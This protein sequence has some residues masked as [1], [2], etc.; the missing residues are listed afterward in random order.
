[1]G[2]EALCLEAAAGKELGERATACVDVVD[3]SCS[4]RR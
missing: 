1:M 2:T 4:G 3:L